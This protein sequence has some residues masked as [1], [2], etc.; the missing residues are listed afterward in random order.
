MNNNL[1]V[2]WYLMTEH[3]CRLPSP[4]T[5]CRLLSANGVALSL[6]RAYGK[7]FLQRHTAQLQVEHKVSRD[8]LLN[9]GESTVQAQHSMFQCHRRELVAWYI[10]QARLWRG[11]LRGDFG[12]SLRDFYERDFYGV[13]VP[14]SVP[15]FLPRRC[16]GVNNRRI[17][18]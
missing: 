2:L 7:S 6:F 3:L 16:A 10:F 14:R 9:N 4:E 12:E 13:S 11:N 17:R 15:G 18:Y 8:E 5:L 1:D